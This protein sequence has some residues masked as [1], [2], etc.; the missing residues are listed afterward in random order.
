MPVPTDFN[1]L[2]LSVGARA[3]VA[4]TPY[5]RRRRQQHKQKPWANDL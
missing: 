4:A 3:A 2:M 5:V 1:G